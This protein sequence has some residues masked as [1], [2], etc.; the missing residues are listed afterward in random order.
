MVVV[1]VLLL[2]EEALFT[3]VPALRVDD[4]VFLVLSLLETFV[5]V[6]LEGVVDLVL[7][8]VVVVFV[9]DSVLV[10]EGAT[11]VDFLVVLEEAFFL[12]LSC[13]KA[14]L[15]TRNAVNIVICVFIASVFKLY[16][17][18]FPNSMPNIQHIG[19]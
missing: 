14:K 16:A 12:V 2:P 19:L 18:E 6:V 13:E 15:I 1:T 10:L 11:F 5:R 9:P 7:V 8:A 3:V 17:E 4:V